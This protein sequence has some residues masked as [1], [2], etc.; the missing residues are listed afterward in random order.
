MIKRFNTTARLSSLVSYPLTGTMIHLAGLCS[1]DDTADASQQTVDVLAKIDKLLAEAG[2][3]RED[4]V[5]A[6]IWLS[7][8]SDYDAMNTIWDAWVPLGHA[9]VR[10]CVEAKLAFD[11][12]KVE[13]QVQA[14]IKNTQQPD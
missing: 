3:S 6:W 10:A 5:S 14:I 2:A 12:L 9:P 8:I 7:D 1:D 11:F 13:I 4:I